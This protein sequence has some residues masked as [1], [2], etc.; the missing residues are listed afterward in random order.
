MTDTTATPAPA[1]A[2]TAAPTPTAAPATPAAAL[3]IGAAVGMAERAL[4]RRLTS[5]L[6]ETGTPTLTWYAFQRLSTF[7]TPPSPEAF[8]R[9][10]C[11]ELDLDEA[12]TAT[13][14]DEIMAAGFARETGGGAQIVFTDTGEARRDRIRGALAPRAAELTASL[15]PRD[16]ETT[17]RTLTAIT[18]RARALSGQAR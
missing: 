3:N 6:A 16:V 12:A 15:D 18:A 14:V 9:D 13:L 5:V 8:R 17:V 1:P 2:P 10:L 7:G 11:V 4:T